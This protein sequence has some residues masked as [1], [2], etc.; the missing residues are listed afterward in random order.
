MS[1][2]NRSE[3]R[4]TRV[5]ICGATRKRIFH[6]HEAAFAFM[7]DKPELKRSYVCKFC[8]GIHVTIRRHD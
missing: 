8:A 5:D 3:A 7:S 1:K 4:K 2:F 6:S